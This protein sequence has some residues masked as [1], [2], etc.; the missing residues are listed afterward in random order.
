MYTREHK[1]SI[2]LTLPKLHDLGIYF[3][4]CWHSLNTSLFHMWNHSCNMLAL[5][6]VTQ[7]LGLIFLLLVSTHI[8]GS[9][10]QED[11]LSL[12]TVSLK[13]RET[14]HNSLMWI[15]EPYPWPHAPLIRFSN[16][17]LEWHHVFGFAWILR[18]MSLN[19]LSGK[20]NSRIPSH[21]TYRRRLFKLL[22]WKVSNTLP[23][24]KVARCITQVSIR[25]KQEVEIAFFKIMQKLYRQT[26][27]MVTSEPRKRFSSS[28]EKQKRSTSHIIHVDNTKRENKQTNNKQCCCIT[29]KL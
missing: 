20:S 4:C 17:S 18:K 6:M 10:T 8:Q 13:T 27:A 7:F 28:E 19:L 26:P 29:R 14:Q 2:S 9:V 5:K 21:R 11:Q 12:Q 3:D 25:Q 24:E 15:T 16:S 1:I 22:Y 23:R